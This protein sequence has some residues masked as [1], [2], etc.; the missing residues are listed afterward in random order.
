M[1]ERTVYELVALRVWQP[2]RGSK[3]EAV[4]VTP[5]GCFGS[6]RSQ[7]VF[8]GSFP[9]RLGD[10]GL[11]SSEEGLQLY[12]LTP[13]EK[14][15]HLSPALPSFLPCSSHAGVSFP[16]ISAPGGE[17]SFSL[18]QPHSSRLPR[19]YPNV[20]RSDHGGLDFREDF[21]REPRLPV[22]G[23]EE[24]GSGPLSL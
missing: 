16:E 17:S 12:Q 23:M 2:W 13:Q 21:G 8:L 10:G 5:R 20:P 11:S 9:L 18:S 24:L 4:D 7:L 3:W 15:R 1:W 22:K 19:R 14:P 6:G